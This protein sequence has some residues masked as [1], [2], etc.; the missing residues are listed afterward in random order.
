MTHRSPLPDV[1]IPDE[2]LTTY[3][4]YRARELGDKPALVDGPTGRVLTY[5]GL[6][7]AEKE[8]AEAHKAARAAHAEAEKARREVG[9]LE[10]S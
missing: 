10:R 5:A 1:D 3:A 7:Q 6:E 9:R 8:R 4:L 2:A